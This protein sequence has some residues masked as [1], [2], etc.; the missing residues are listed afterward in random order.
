ME[1]SSTMAPRPPADFPPK[2]SVCFAVEA[3]KPC[4]CTISSS[5]ALP[6]APALFPSP[7]GAGVGGGGW[8]APPLAPQVAQ[9]WNAA[10]DTQPKPTEKKA[11][12]PSGGVNYS[13][14]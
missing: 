3:P 11:P 7:F 10:A 1:S 8:G 4:V 5:T 14:W 2:M 9:S 12:G 6:T 13:L